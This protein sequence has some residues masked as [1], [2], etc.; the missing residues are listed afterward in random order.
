VHTLFLSILLI[1]MQVQSQFPRHWSCC[2]YITQIQ[3]NGVRENVHSF[4][5][6]S[7]IPIE[8]LLEAISSIGPVMKG[9][10]VGT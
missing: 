5:T 9:R 8:E 7:V 6:L 4:Q 2:E 3:T 10:Q 1:L